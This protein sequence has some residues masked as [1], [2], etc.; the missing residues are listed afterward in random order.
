MNEGMNKCTDEIL[1]SALTVFLPFWNLICEYVSPFVY[2]FL[3]IPRNGAL[4]TQRNERLSVKWLNADLGMNVSLLF[5][6][7]I[8]KIY[9]DRVEFSLSF[10]VIKNSY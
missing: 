10:G 7:V 4:F 5:C 9:L 8:L 1:Y 2:M 3:C 6:F